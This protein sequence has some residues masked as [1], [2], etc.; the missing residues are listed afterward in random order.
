MPVVFS[1]TPLVRFSVTPHNA[2]CRLI[3]PRPL[4]N[5][6]AMRTVDPATAPRQLL[7][8]RRDVAHVLGISEA[9]VCRLDTSGDLHPIRLPNLR[10]V[11][12]SADEVTALATRWLNQTAAEPA[13]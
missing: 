11:R 1:V 8:R 4:F 2:F 5:M 10:S 6:W 12:Y 3:P 7:Y 9:L 13:Q